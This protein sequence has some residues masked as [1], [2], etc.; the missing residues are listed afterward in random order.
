MR[1]FTEVKVPRR[2]A[3][4]VMIPKKI[5]TMFSHDPLVGE[6]CI[7]IRGLRASQACTP[8]QCLA[9]RRPLVD[10]WPLLGG[11]R[12]DLGSRGEPE[13]GKDALDV[14]LGGPLSDH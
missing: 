8:L 7:V 2:M 1:S 14:T 6:K 13:F 5:S 3:W 9:M 11:P 4:R 12:G 10:L